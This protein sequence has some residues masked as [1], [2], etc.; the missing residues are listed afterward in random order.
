MYATYPT[1]L[2]GAEFARWRV[3]WHSVELS[4]TC[5]E[6]AQHINYT[7][8]SINNYQPGLRVTF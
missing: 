8:W 4:P 1:S 3:D 6:D 7:S 5:T 2:P